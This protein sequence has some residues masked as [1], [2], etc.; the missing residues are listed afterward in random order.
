MSDIGYRLRSDRYPD[1]SDR[2][3]TPYQIPNLAVE[4]DSLSLLMFSHRVSHFATVASD[5]YQHFH[6]RE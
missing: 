4:F 2:Y 3:D 1:I 5:G 6:R